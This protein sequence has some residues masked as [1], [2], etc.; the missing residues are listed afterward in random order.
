[1]L[2]I[3]VFVKNGIIR[4][5]LHFISKGKYF[6]F[7]HR[8]FFAVG[9]KKLL[10]WRNPVYFYTGMY[11]IFFYCSRSSWQKILIPERDALKNRED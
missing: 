1:M 4:E 8:F 11:E 10:Y 3:L 9:C 5:N 7:A 6:I 2:A